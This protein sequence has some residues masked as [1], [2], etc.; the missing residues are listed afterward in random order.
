VQAAIRW[1]DDPLSPGRAAQFARYRLAVKLVWYAGPRLVELAGLTWSSVDLERRQLRILGEA[2][3][4]GRKDRFVPL[5]LPLVSELETVPLDKRRPK[6]HV[7]QLPDGSAPSYRGVEHI[8]DR[9]LLKR[10]GVE[11]L[12]AHR[13]RH[14]FATIALEKGVNI[15]RIQRWLGHANLSTTER[16]L[17]L[18]D[19]GD[20]D[21]IDLMSA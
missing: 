11:P 16:Y 6:L 17:G 13:V 19:D 1:P 5:A 8:F 21:D 4:K 20:L 12:G 15:R 14:T 3:A 2:G 9:W 18:V 10:S 7:L